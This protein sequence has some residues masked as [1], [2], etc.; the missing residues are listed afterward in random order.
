ML[1][2]FLN[3]LAL[4]LV[5][6]FL[7]IDLNLAYVNSCTPLSLPNLPSPPPNCFVIATGGLQK[8]NIARSPQP[9]LTEP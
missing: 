9:S 4:V 3:G 8:L 5:A 6:Q 7:S 2:L 1:C